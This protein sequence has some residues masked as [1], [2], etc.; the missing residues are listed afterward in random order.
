MQVRVPSANQGRQGGESSEDACRRVPVPAGSM[1]DWLHMELSE[2]IALEPQV[3]QSPVLRQ[4]PMESC[5]V[6][7]LECSDT[8]SAHCKLSLPNSS[9]SPASASR[10]NMKSGMSVSLSQVTYS[11]PYL[12]LAIPLD[13]GELTERGDDFKTM[14]MNQPAQHGETLST[15]THTHTHFKEP[16]MLLTRLRLEDVLKPGVQVQPGQQTNTLIFIQFDDIY[17]EIKNFT[18]SLRLECS[19]AISAHCDL[20][21]PGSIEA[22]FHIAGHSGLKLL[23]SND[24]PTLASQ[25]I[26]CLSFRVAGITGSHQHAQL[27]VVFLVETRFHHVGQAGLKL[28]TS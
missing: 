27:I 25:S 13:F 2:H 26:S 17:M 22:G 12:H 28:L 6:T 23:T 16:G 24:P 4:R 9:N 7:R 10:I 20:C 1:A 8:I 19:G 18:L 15:H 5:S 14:Q 11:H 21:L 3:G